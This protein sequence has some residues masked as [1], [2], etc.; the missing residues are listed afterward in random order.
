M[1]DWYGMYKDGAGCGA[2]TVMSV[3]CSVGWDDI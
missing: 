1:Q 3:G 2:M